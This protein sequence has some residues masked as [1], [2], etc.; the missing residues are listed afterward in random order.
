[1]EKRNVWDWIWDISMLF[2][3]LCLR[4]AFVAARGF[5]LVAVTGGSFLVVLRLP[6][7]AASPA[8]HMFASIHIK[9][10]GT[11]IKNNSVRQMQKSFFFFYN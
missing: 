1:M 10:D 5:S 8:A 3:F 4:W 6:T 11:K 7:A 2:F 9:N